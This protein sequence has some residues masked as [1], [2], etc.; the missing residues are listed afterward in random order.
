MKS[1]NKKI[2]FIIPSLGAGGA[3]RVLTIMANYWALSN[4]EVTV[5]TFTSPVEPPFYSLDTS[6]NY[7][8]LDL[9]KESSNVFSATWNNLRRLNALRKSLKV[10]QPDVAISFL[11]QTNVITLLATR[12]HKFSVFVAEH[13]DPYRCPIPFTWAVLRKLTYPWADQIVTLTKE[14]K[15]FFS[16][17]LQ[18]KIK[19]IPNPIIPSKI[20]KS[21]PKPERDSVVLAMGRLSDQKGFDNLL[22][23]FSVVASEFPAWHLVVLGQ[24]P[25]L[26]KL[27]HLTE[28]LE[29]KERVDFPGVVNEPGPLFKRAGIFVLSSRYE[30]FPMGL[31]EAMAHG[32]PV[33]STEYSS[34]VYDLIQPGSNGVIVPREDIEALSEALRSLIL[35]SALRNKLG[36]AATAITKKFGLDGIM[37]VWDELI[38]TYAAQTGV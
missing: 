29:I 23:A 30:G 21:A 34:S 8:S 1:D 22:R 2:V 15:S 31:C 27:G 26:N 16:T 28:Q 13:N 33:I 20:E 3:E 14:A 32:C 24:G 11:T 36:T 17:K 5:L 10:I 19:V 35:D 18:S 7:Q 12:W 25:D 38:S 6:I 37:K 4:R 9:L